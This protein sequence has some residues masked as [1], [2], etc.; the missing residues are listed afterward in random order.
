MKDKLEAIRRACIEANPEIVEL[1]FGCRVLYRHPTEKDLPSPTVWA[2]VR[3]HENLT[4]S[5]VDNLERVE[6]VSVLNNDVQIYG[7]E[8]R[9]ADVLCAMSKKDDYFILSDTSLAIDYKG[10]FFDPV[11]E[12]GE[13]IRYELAN[14]DLTLQ[15]PETIDFLFEL[16][17]PSV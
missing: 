10:Y 13:G 14:D 11:N 8:I 15:S 6:R 16:L 2:F 12:L 7:R 4:F 1:K 3:H 17:K 5:I 9:L